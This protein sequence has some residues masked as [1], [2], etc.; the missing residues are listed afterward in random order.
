MSSVLPRMGHK[1]KTGFVRS[2]ADRTSIRYALWQ[3]GEKPARRAIVFLNGRTEWLE[4]YQFI[5]DLLQVDDETCVLSWAHRG[6]GGSGGERSHVDHYDQFCD[7]GWTV[8]QK[9]LDPDLPFSMVGHSMGA[10]IALY[11]TL[12][13]IFNP[14]VLILSSPL[15]AMPRKPLQPLL[16]R[17]LARA[18][19]RTPLQSQPVSAYNLAKMDFIDNPF[20]HSAEHFARIKASPFIV[21]GPSFGW[22]HA[23][24]EAIAAVFDPDLL[25]NLRAPVLALGAAEE[26]IVDPEGIPAWIKA[27]NR[28]ASVPVNW[29]RI[30]DA[31]HEMFVEV[32]AVQEK[33][34]WYTMDWLKDHGFEAQAP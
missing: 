31:R 15:L 11:G 5:P 4:K 8:I 2:E 33:V 6:Q 29:H 27:A 18:L 13:G 25:K 23:S 14:Q 12:K 17:P 24:F 21:P 22:I 30:P 28:Y 1:W 26:T 3:A 9:A 16:A 20:T 10:L 32:S 34:A 19:S 7:D